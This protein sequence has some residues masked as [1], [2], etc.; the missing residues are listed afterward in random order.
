MR[1]FFAALTSA[2]LLAASASSQSSVPGTPVEDYNYDLYEQA[3][4]DGD[5]FYAGISP[6][7][8]GNPWTFTDNFFITNRPLGL[9]T[10]TLQVLLSLGS[11]KWHFAGITL[12]RI[13]F[14]QLGSRWLD[15][16]TMVD[17]SDLFELA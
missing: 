4:E 9:P 6:G 15:W 5:F 11:K 16:L 10:L 17:L 7:D 8:T 3:E 14:D 13:L 2:L 12:I 1:I